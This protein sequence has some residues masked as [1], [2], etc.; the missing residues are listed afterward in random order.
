MR[1][2]PLL[3]TVLLSVSL[4]A[5]LSGCAPTVNSQSRGE[6]TSS[7]TAPAPVEAVRPA[8]EATTKVAILLPLSGPQANIGQSL[9][10]AAQ[11]AV[12]D[13]GGEKFAL[14]PQDTQGTP[15]GAS[16]AAQ[17]A[18]ADG[19][20]LFI[21]PVFAPE[22]EA[23]RALAHQRNIPILALSNNENLTDT[24][25]YVM[26]LSPLDQVGRALQHAKRQG[27]SRVAALLPN[28]PYGQAVSEAIS[29]EAEL[30][31][32]QL[33]K[34]ARYSATDN[35]TVT[36]QTFMTELNAAGGAQALM[37][38][39]NGAGLLNIAGQ[40]A[41]NGYNP[42]ITRPLGTA[43]WE[44][45]SA[46][47][48]T[49]LVGGWYAAPAGTQRR[50]FNARY[51]Q[52]FGGNPP[53]IAPL[54]YDST[55]LAAVLSRS[56]ARFTEQRMTDPM[57]FNGVDGIFRLHPSGNVER[58]LAVF[59]VGPAGNQLIDAAPLTFATAQTN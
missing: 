55:A 2:F 51:A 34:L 10:N 41:A 58:G 59:E 30:Q 3:T 37:F 42:A 17:R 46:T 29:E 50:A 56:D 32:L 7:Y 19:A 23:V 48:S 28:N 47:R 5:L 31:G 35:L 49:A 57:G 12:Y 14:L 9:L 38:G 24:F 21:G 27:I 15:E 8:A 33:V 18:L 1:T 52:T 45:G 6:A 40:L 13:V 4:P 25:T 16:A 26:G 54:A 36:A 39:E 20:Q 22:V 53:A 43:L 44:D 11:L